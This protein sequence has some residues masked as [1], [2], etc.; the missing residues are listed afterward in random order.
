MV[1]VVKWEGKYDVTGETRGES[2]I[3]RLVRGPRKEEAWS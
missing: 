3:L 2:E 1:R